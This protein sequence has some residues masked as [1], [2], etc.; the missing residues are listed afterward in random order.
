[1]RFIK[2]IDIGYISI[3]FTI[4]AFIFSYILDYF[5]NYMF[6]KSQKQ[7]DKNKNLN[8]IYKIIIMI[9]IT[10][11][12]SYIGRNIVEK[13]PFPL[14]GYQNYNHFKLKELISGTILLPLLLALQVNLQNNILEFKK[15]RTNDFKKK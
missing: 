15:L 13:I 4:I 8:L 5:Y 1:M 2:I 3:L 10:C 14:N 9:I 6:S 12:F 11:I 7:D